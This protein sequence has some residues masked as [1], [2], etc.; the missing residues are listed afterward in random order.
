MYD[1][2]KNLI[3]PLTEGRGVGYALLI[4]ND[5]PLRAKYMTSHAWGERYDHFV[6]AINDSR[7]EG[8][9]WV[10]AMALYQNEDMPSITIS[11]Q[12]GPS[13]ENGPFATVL[14]QATNM[15]AV[16]TPAVDIYTRMW[17]VFEIFM[18]VKSGVNVQFVA[19]SYQYLS[20]MENI[21]DAIFEHGKKAS[22][23]VNARCGNPSKP[24]NSDEKKIR[25][26][27]Q[28]FPGKFDTIDSVIEWC[29]ASYHIRE[30]VHPGMGFR[31]DPEHYLFLGGPGRF[32]FLA[33][34]LSSAALAIDRLE[35]VSERI[36]ERTKSDDLCNTCCIL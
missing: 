27:I 30:A 1:V 19:L 24:I 7:C 15:I 21:Y 3:T 32:D 8:P 25:K 13:I 20:G 36:T 29:K 17:C 23:S 2:V 6:R 31:S 10:C 28:A 35:E 26:L 16:F 33:K 11:K 12:L 34:N 5:K 4:N 22:P 14:K 18:A 9:F